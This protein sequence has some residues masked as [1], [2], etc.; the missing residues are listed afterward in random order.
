MK[1]TLRKEQG[2][3]RETKM[4]YHA[5]LLD[6]ER[7]QEAYQILEAERDALVFSN[8][9]ISGEKKYSEHKISGLETQRAT[10]DTQAEEIR[11][12]VAEME[13]QNGCWRLC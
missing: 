7:L 4:K 10:V 9:I 5:T 12:R 6:L 2:V 8:T 11:V 1:E 3:H 13:P